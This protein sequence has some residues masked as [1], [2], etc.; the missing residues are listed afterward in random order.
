MLIISNSIC[1]RVHLYITVIFTDDIVMGYVAIFTM[2]GYLCTI[3]L[4]GHISPM[5]CVNVDTMQ[6]QIFLS[7]FMF[8]NITTELINAKSAKKMARKRQ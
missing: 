3:L 8:Y 1:A 5:I 7:L 2:C 6:L 4:T